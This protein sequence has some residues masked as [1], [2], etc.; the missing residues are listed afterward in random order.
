M[1]FSGSETIKAPREKVFDFL[2][3]PKNF[4]SGIPDIKKI[5]VISPEKFKVVAKLGI[6]FLR[7]TF[8]IDFDVVEKE[9]PS[10]TR[11]KGHGTGVGSAV[12]LDIV[13]DLEEQDSNTIMKWKADAKVAG[14]LASL[15]QRMLGSVA[16][17]LVREIFENIHRGIE[18]Q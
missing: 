4:S 10:H 2:T 11:L 15:G 1:E 12:D 18:K 9:R 5:E 7:G 17:K 14:M 6:S 8:T 13:V 3:D 16:E